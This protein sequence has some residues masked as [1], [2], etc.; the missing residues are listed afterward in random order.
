MRLR[1]LVLNKSWMPVGYLTWRKSFCLIFKGKAEA[2]EYYS[3]TVKTPSSEFFVPAVIRLLTSSRV[4]SYKTLFSRK[5]ILHRD[6]YS[7][8]YCEQRLTSTSAT[9]DHVIP[10]SK[11]GATT[12]L[13]VVAACITCNNKKGAKLLNQTSMR[14]K[15]KPFVPQ[16]PSYQLAIG[17]HISDEWIPYLPR[18]IVDEQGKIQASNNRR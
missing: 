2:L 7:C 6:K 16:I 11:G 12:F 15:R 9:M 5:A 8:Q 10:R 13:N 18:G 3:N 14:L 17:N 4:P 1:T